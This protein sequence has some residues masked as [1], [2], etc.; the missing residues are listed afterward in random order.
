MTMA[1][2]NITLFKQQEA[3]NQASFQGHFGRTGQYASNVT[4][5]SLRLW[6]DFLA[7]KDVIPER[8]QQLPAPYADCWAGWL[9]YN[10][11]EL[12]K[13]HQLFVSSHAA[14][15][16]QADA[17][18]AIDTSLGLGRLYTRTGHFAAAR[19][20]LLQAGD[21]A[22]IHDRLYDIVRSF[23]AL[24]DLF[25]RTG[26][27]Q[28]SLF[29]LNTAHQTLPAGAGERSRQMNYL[30]TV[31]MRLGTPQDQAT[32]EDLLMQSFYLARD[33]HDQA[34]MLHSLARLQFL[35]LDRQQPQTDV[36]KLLGLQEPQPAAAS[37]P[38][39]KIPAGFLALA[40]SFAA[41]LNQQTVRAAE[42]AEQACQLLKNHPAEYYWARSLA[43]HLKGTPPP[44]WQTLLP[45]L[46]PA[47][48]P[49]SNSVISR[50]WRELELGNPGASVF[51]PQTQL[52]SLISH[53]QVFFL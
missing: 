21:Q 11:G 27:S 28:Q 38:Q 40:R 16:P 41:A 20:W 33:V 46:Q 29:C 2:T 5:D 14:L 23:G 48:A 32:A 45:V 36:Y 7:K 17:A 22:R 9:A 53:R 51:Q 19:D 43:G 3:F 44:D 49:A 18:L 24:G 42:L 26:F 31:L 10:R 30:A 39:C 1:H 13:A 6:L 37:S 52:D 4:D 47:S 34:S 12:A 15:D 8:L 35:Y 50:Q 25:L